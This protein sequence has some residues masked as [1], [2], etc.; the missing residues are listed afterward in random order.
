MINTIITSLFDHFQNNIFD[1]QTVLKNIE[2]L[3]EQKKQ[4]MMEAYAVDDEER[5]IQIQLRNIGVTDWTSI[6][7][8]IKNTDLANINGQREEDENYNMTNYAGEND[9]A[10][11]INDDA[12]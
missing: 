12:F 6:F 9:D 11:E 10:D 4:T 7:D 8:R 2:E 5:T 3:R 1:N